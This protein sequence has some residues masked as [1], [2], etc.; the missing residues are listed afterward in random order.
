MRSIAP[1]LALLLLAG[2]ATK[3]PL[4]TTST[5]PICAALIGPIQYNS[6]KPASDRFAGPA[7]APDLKRRNQVGEQLHCPKYR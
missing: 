6:Q 5:T 4:K 1:I 2:C 7:L 3:A